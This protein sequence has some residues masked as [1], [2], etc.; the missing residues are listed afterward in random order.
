MAGTRGPNI[1]PSVKHYIS[2]KSRERYDVPREMLAREL[3]NDLAEMGEIQPSE[4]TTIKM[5]SKARNLDPYPE[6][7]PWSLATLSQYPISAEALPY[8]MQAWINAS[9]D[10]R[11]AFTVR[12]AK[13]VS[14]LYVIFKEDIKQLVHTARGYSKF[15]MVSEVFDDIHDSLESDL[16]L[17]QIVSGRDISADLRSKI[18]EAGKSSFLSPQKL[19]KHKAEIVKAEQQFDQNRKSKIDIP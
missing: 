10:Y 6:D 11:S 13:W 4:E 15:E 12:D 1:R 9:A 3:I 17:F 14:W 16:K 2:A 5:I 7:L 18:A 8:V 19:Q